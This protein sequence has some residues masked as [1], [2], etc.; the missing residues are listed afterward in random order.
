M[1]DSNRTRKLLTPMVNYGIRSVLCKS[2]NTTF[3]LIVF[4]LKQK[5]LLFFTDALNVSEHFKMEY[6][7]NSK[8]E[9]IANV[10]FMFYLH[11]V[12]TNAANL[13]LVA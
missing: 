2:K 9:N 10:I 13:L 4:C 11:H 1:K 3:I 7:T 5:V 6:F 8:G 12:A